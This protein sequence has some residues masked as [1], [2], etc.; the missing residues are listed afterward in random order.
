MAAVPP[1]E[2]DLAAHYEKEKA[3]PAMKKYLE[4]LGIDP[5]YVGPAD[6][7][8]RVVIS[9]FAIIFRDHPPVVL[10]FNNEDDVR[11]AASTPMVVKEGSEFKIRVTFRVQHNVVLGLKILNNVS[12]LGKTVASDE[13]MLGT[14]PPKNEYQTLELPR[15]DWNEAPSG[16]LLRGDYKSKM[17][18]VD[19]DNK[20]H[21][22]FAYILRISREWSE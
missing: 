16:M 9:E 11:R 2:V 13:E 14:Y 15:L 10:R 7:P 21:L 18:F 8:R 4:S 6:D 3:D 5:N 17:K 22:K 19:D 1:A 12:K 20:T